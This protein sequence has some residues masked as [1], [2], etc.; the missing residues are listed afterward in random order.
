MHHSPKCPSSLQLDPL[1]P[2][3]VGTKR[4]F[5]CPECPLPVPKS[6][7]EVS[8]AVSTQT[9][10]PEVTATPV[11][12]KRPSLRILQPEVTYTGAPIKPLQRGLPKTTESLCPE[13]TRV[14]APRKNVENREKN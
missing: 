14:I 4:V 12:Q 5:V 8:F 11:L 3:M 6:L 1:Q 10:S 2:T 9:I 13:C 7:S